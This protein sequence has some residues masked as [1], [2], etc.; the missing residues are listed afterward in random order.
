MIIIVCGGRKYGTAIYA[1]G[2]S[3]VEQ[4]AEERR[5]RREA[6]FLWD[7]LDRMHRGY[8]IKEIIH[9]KAFGADMHAAQ[10]AVGNRISQTGYQADWHRYGRRAGIIRN[11]TMFDHTFGR[12]DAII[13]FPGG[14]GT[15]HM[16]ATGLD[17]YRMGLWDGFVMEFAP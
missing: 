15:A 12:L 1:D 3:K 7:C 11:H 9:G 13:G 4:R 16:L 2:M 5:A 8:P 17:A 6:A 10:W 14:R